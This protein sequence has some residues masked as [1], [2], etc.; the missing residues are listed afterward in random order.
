MM[1]DPDKIT[2]TGVIHLVKQARRDRTLLKMSIPGTGYECLTIVTGTDNRN[3]SSAFF[4]DC[5]WDAKEIGKDVEGK[6]VHFEFS[7]QDRIRYSFRTY[8][9]GIEAKN[10]RIRYP[11]TVKRIQRR[12]SFRIMAPPG[13]MA[14]AAITGKRYYF[15]VA[16]LSEGGAL[17]NQKESFHD[18]RLLYAGSHIE[19][20]LLENNEGPQRIRIKVRKADITRIEKESKTG[21]YSYAIRFVEMGRKEEEE[22]RG[23]IY[24][25]QRQILKKRSLL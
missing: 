15:H 4:I 9:E 21:R 17:L 12:K 18:N 8:M 13:T 10:L 24:M 14:E 25:C 6:R 7:G 22:I 2:G 3:P 16:N 1:E 20:L 23:F 11:E 5:P 19:D